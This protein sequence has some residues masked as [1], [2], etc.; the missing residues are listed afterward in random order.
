MKCQ[1]SGKA[2]DTGERLRAGGEVGDGIEITG[3]ESA[4]LNMPTNLENSAVAMKRKTM[5]KNAQTTAQ[6]YSSH[7]L[8]K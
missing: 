5:P 1:L 4:A 2:P 3:C 7:M 6:L 8:V